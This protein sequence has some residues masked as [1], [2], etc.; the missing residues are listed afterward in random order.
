MVISIPNKSVSVE[1][2]CVHLACGTTHEMPRYIIAF[3]HAQT[4]QIAVHVTIDIFHLVA[5]LETGIISKMREKN[6]EN[7]NKN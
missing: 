3:A 6:N 5:C 4:W 7:K 1:V 2:N